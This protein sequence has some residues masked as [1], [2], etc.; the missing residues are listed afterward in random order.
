MYAHIGHDVEDFG[1]SRHFTG[2]TLWLLPVSFP[3]EVL[4]QSSFSVCVLT[5]TCHLGV[6][7]DLTVELVSRSVFT[8]H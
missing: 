5:C 2:D 4:T 3:Q 8:F 6:T 7:Y 1:S